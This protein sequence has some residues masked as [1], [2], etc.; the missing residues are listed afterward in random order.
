M[1][2]WN[3]GTRISAGFAIVILIAGALGVFAYTRV[4]MIQQSA[5]FH[6]GTTLARF[7][8]AGGGGRGNH[9]GDGTDGCK[10]SA[11]CR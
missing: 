1:N 11:E 3:I 6:R 5:E 4:G 7:H 9:G 8:R 10:H 2:N